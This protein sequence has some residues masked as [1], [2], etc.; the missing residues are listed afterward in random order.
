MPVGWRDACV[1]LL[2]FAGASHL[3]YFLA[4]Q[5]PGFESSGLAGGTGLSERLEA[6]GLGVA[7][8]LFA[9]LPAIC[10]ELIFRG[11]LFSMLERLA[12]DRL[13]LVGSAALFGLV[14]LEP[15][16]A[17]VAF[18]LGLQLGMLRL[19]HGLPLAIAAHFAGNA[20]AVA[21]HA[22]EVPGRL[23]PGAALLTLPIAIAAA[24]SAWASLVHRARSSHATASARRTTLQTPPQRD[25]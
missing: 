9:L 24:G 13:A 6:H 14:H 18:A 20:L 8:V 21:I 2:G 4:A 7:L 19:V 11:A 12:G 1:Q 25:E 22:A 10:E 23:P 3:L 15:L 5:H 17:G 16:H